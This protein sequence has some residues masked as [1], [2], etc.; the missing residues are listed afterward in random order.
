MEQKHKGWFFFI[1]EKNP[2]VT[3]KENVLLVQDVFLHLTIAYIVFNAETWRHVLT[4]V[5]A[6]LSG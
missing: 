6:L 5:D 2:N 1:Q 3:L 4:E